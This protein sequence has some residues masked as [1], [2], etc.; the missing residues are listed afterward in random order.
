MHLGQF[1]RPP[2]QL[3]LL[4]FLLGNQQFQCLG[5]LDQLAFECLVGLAQYVEF[6]IQFG[7]HAVGPRGE[8][9]ANQGD[10]FGNGGGKLDGKAGNEGGDRADFGGDYVDQRRVGDGFP[11]RFEQVANAGTV[12]AMVAFDGNLVRLQQLH[13]ARP[14]AG[15]GVDD[16]DVAHV[17]KVMQRIEAAIAAIDDLG[18]G[19]LHLLAQGERDGRAVTVIP[20]QGIAEA[21]DAEPDPV[22]H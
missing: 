1:A 7:H 11:H 10:G 5:A 2:L 15:H 13:V 4:F 8:A 16:D 6:G 17:F 21:E 18:A 3:V 22:R 19:A 20:V 12:A 14:G 9:L